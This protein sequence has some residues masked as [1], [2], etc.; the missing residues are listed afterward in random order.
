MAQKCRSS[1]PLFHNDRRHSTSTGKERQLSCDSSPIHWHWTAVNLHNLCDAHVARLLQQCV[2][3]Y[4]ASKYTSN[5]V[6]KFNVIRIPCNRLIIWYSIQQTAQSMINNHLAGTAPP[7]KFYLHEF[8][9]REVYKQLC[10]YKYST[11]WMIVFFTNLMNRFFI[12][13]HLFYSPIRF[14]H[15]YAHLQKDKSY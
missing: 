7:T 2:L 9:I 14:E 12:L 11:F 13:I 6:L 4:Q 8:I 3:S 15:Y 10:E 1:S 5:P